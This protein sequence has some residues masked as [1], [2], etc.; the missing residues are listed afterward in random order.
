MRFLIVLVLFS[1]PL[2]YAGLSG[3][4]GLAYLMNQQRI[5]EIRDKNTSPADMFK[6]AVTPADE[7][8][9]DCLGLSSSGS[10]TPVQDPLDAFNNSA[11]S[12]IFANAQLTDR[13]HLENK[14]GREAQLENSS[15]A[16]ELTG[17]TYAK[18]PE[19]ITEGMN[20]TP[21]SSGISK[22]KLTDDGRKLTI[23][24]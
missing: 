3:G 6:R 17:T 18:N 20:G 4:S 22:A 5:E 9:D 8:I 7:Q 24:G 16:R 23:F 2:V 10:A 19:E 15:A 21:G 12:M 14:L 1:I 11:G 13:N